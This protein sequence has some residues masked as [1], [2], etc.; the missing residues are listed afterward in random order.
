[1]GLFTFSGLETFVFD[2]AALGL[3]MFRSLGSAAVEKLAG[4]RA[5]VLSTGRPTPS[6]EDF[7]PA[8]TLAQN[9]SLTADLMLAAECSDFLSD[10]EPA[11]LRCACIR[12]I[13]YGEWS[14]EGIFGVFLGGCGWV[15][16]WVGRRGY[17]GW[18]A[19]F[20]VSG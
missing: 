13:P 1:M 15:G 8:A 17:T 3:K 9:K 4:E 20:V 11:E 14:G 7:S 10:I 16:G 2:N 6:R 12:G 5:R 19:C 18:S